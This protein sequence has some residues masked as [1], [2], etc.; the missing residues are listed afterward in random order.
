[1]QDKTSDRSG[2][3]LK[4]VDWLRVILWIG[5]GLG[6]I[7]A[8]F[9]G[10]GIASIFIWILAALAIKHGLL[11]KKGIILDRGKRTLT[12]PALIIS[13]DSGFDFKNS[14]KA[15][16][17]C[18]TIN[19]SDIKSIEYANRKNIRQDLNGNIKT[20]RFINIEM[21]LTYGSA[22]ISMSSG[23]NRLFSELMDACGANPNFQAYESSRTDVK[24]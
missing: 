16:R 7:S 21:Q 6:M 1:M 23:Q 9:Q 15:F 18:T 8:S 19:L 3:V 14:L 20:Q 5:G 22:T 4:V 10:F 17:T 13:Y 11:V 24:L 12:V 2:D